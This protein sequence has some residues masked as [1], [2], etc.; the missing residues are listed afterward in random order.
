MSRPHRTPHSSSQARSK[1]L[2]LLADRYVAEQVHRL[3][4]MPSPSLAYTTPAH[5][6]I[7]VVPPE[8]LVAVVKRTAR[9][10]RHTPQVTA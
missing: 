2:R 1:E 7:D 4:P 10:L 6:P 9:R 5:W 3:G 8:T